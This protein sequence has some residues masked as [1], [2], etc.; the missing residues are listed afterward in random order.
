MSVDCL[1]GISDMELDSDFTIRTIP[2]QIEDEGLHSGMQY[3]P[4]PAVHEDTVRNSFS[5]SPAVSGSSNIR[6]KSMK[7]RRI[8]FENRESLGLPGIIQVEHLR[9]EPSY[10][11][12]RLVHL[13]SRT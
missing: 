4:A 12:N 5:I 6:S 9:F 3:S 13:C 10:R 1:P 7:S 11:S 8:F 2:L